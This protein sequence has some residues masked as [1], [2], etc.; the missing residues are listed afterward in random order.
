MMC[1]S[2]GEISTRIRRQL[3]RLKEKRLGWRCPTCGSKPRSNGRCPNEHRGS[4]KPPPGKHAPPRSPSA[5]NFRQPREAAD[6]E[7]E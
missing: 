5:N 6:K 2:D 1:N 7:R 3:R 4:G